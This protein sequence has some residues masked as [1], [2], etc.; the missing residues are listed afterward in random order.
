MQLIRY[1][2]VQ[3]QAY[4]NY[5]LEWEATGETIVP[6]A[7]TRR[8][9]SFEALQEKWL[10]DDVN[11]EGCIAKGFVPSTLYF[12]V[13]T[14][15]SLDSNENCYDQ[16][17]VG[18]IHLR[19]F[20]NERLLVDGGHIGYGVRPSERTKGH[21]KS[22]LR[23]LIGLLEENGYDRVML[24]CNDDNV[25]SGHTIEACGGK[26]QAKVAF[27]GVMTRHYWI[28]LNPLYVVWLR[29]INVGGHHK[30]PMASLKRALEEQGYL[31]VRTY[32]QTGNL[33]VNAPEQTA[34]MVKEKVEDTIK[35]VFDLSITAIVHPSARMEQVIAD[36]PFVEQ[37]QEKEKANEKKQTTVH[38]VYCAFLEN[39]LSQEAKHA[40]ESAVPQDDRIVCHRD[41]LYLYLKEGAGK[42]KL[43]VGILEKKIG[44][45]ATARNMNTLNAMNRM[46]QGQ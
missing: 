31:N 17:I 44:F 7:S 36:C 37:E 29:A 26:L 13:E 4:L 21:A 14:P 2:Q 20:L 45:L 33:L 24:T 9:L 43:N 30:I 23:C 35:N 41:I 1:D 6:W 11:I 38:H 12:Y 15:G 46:I 39:E 3:E 5:I 32:L 27:E 28:G 25:G 40:L 22:M 42:S 34:Q 10:D 19:H 16:R 8:G 18:A